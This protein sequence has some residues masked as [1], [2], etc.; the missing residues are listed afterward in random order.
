MF[1]AYLKQKTKSLLIAIHYAIC[2]VLETEKT[3]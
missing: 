1:D 2:N 3:K